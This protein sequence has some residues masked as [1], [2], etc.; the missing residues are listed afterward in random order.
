MV[1]TAPNGG[2]YRLY[3]RLLGEYNVLIA[4]TIGSGKSV[5]ECGIIYNLVNKFTPHDGDLYL[6]DPKLVELEEWRSLPHV[7]GYADN[8]EDALTL[9]DEVQARMMKRYKVMKDRGE[10]VFSGSDV[11]VL[12]DEMADLMIADKK[13]FSTRLQRI[14]QLG[15][16]AK[17]HLI[18]CTQSASRVTIPAAVGIGF[19]CCVGLHAATAIESRQII[20]KAGCEA[21]PLYGKA[22][23]KWQNGE[24]E[25]VDVPMYTPAHHSAMRNYYREQR[26]TYY[27]NLQHSM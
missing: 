2:A 23:I 6:I 25:T 5:T 27:S 14:L 21:L 26:V 18:C 24:Y 17:I 10:K 9:L 8:L 22:I 4:G 3:D 1:Y 19:T 7:R 13:G 16:A 20:G 15:R 11:Y 12:I